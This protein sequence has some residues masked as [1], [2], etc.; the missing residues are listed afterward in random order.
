[1]PPE[2]I[3]PGG[4]DRPS[5]EI[6]V[7]GLVPQDTVLRMDVD[8]DFLDTSN[9][10]DNGPLRPEEPVEIVVRCPNHDIA[11][12]VLTLLDETYFPEDS[13]GVSDYLPEVIP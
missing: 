6:F 10:F 13:E 1:M 3:G 4:S 12:S 5:R 2:R 7:P 11:Y 9:A 8:L